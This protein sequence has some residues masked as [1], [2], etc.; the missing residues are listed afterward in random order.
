[1]LIFA[2]VSRTCYGSGIHTSEKKKHLIS[3]YSFLT[4]KIRGISKE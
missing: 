4:P 3:T 1:M 2:D